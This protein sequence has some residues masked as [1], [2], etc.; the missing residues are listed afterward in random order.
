MKKTLTALIIF[1][2]ITSAF[3]QNIPYT[4]CTNCWNADSL[5][6]HRVLLQFDGNGNYAKVVIEWRRR[7][8]HPE[9]KRIIIEDA[10]TLQRI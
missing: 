7:D 3:S 8:K 6:N 4:N 1:F 10:K 2:I 5:S 9:Q